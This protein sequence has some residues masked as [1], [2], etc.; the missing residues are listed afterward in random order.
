MVKKLKYYSIGE[1]NEYLKRVGA[2]NVSFYFCEPKHQFVLQTE[3]GYYGMNDKIDLEAEEETKPKKL[4]I[5]GM[6]WEYLTNQVGRNLHSTDTIRI[7]PQARRNTKCIVLRRG[8][9]CL[10]SWLLDDDSFL[11]ELEKLTSDRTRD[12][13]LGDLFDFDTLLYG[14]CD[15]D[16]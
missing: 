6:L 3:K 1:L 8:K 2:D 11:R 15:H 7:V 9:D 10:V 12:Y 16:C 13:T 5:N 14:K 4:P